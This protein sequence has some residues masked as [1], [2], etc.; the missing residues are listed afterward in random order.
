MF[1]VLASQLRSEDIVTPKRLVDL[2][3]SSISPLLKLYS[4]GNEYFLD[5]LKT[6]IFYFFSLIFNWLFLETC[7]TLKS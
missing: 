4:G 3:T 7:S 6:M 1:D 5:V 2:T